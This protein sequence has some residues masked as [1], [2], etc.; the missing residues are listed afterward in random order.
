VMGELYLSGEGLA[1]GYYRRE[2]LSAEKFLD[3][4]FYD[5]QSQHGRRMYK[6]GDLVRW[7]DNGEL[8]YLGRIDN[9][10]KIRGFRIE[11]GE[12][13][14]QLGLC[15]DVESAFVLAKEIAG[16]KQ[17]VAYV[18][19]SVT[20]AQVE[21][22]KLINSIKQTLTLYLPDYMVP[23]IYVLL[24]S[25]PL[26][27]NGKIDQ[28]ALPE[29]QSGHYADLYTLPETHTEKAM[30]SIWS[31]LLGIDED[32]ICATTSFFEL[33]GNSLLVMRM[34]AKIK[35]AFNLKLNFEQLFREP[36][37]QSIANKLDCLV[38]VKGEEADQRTSVQAI[39]TT[40]RVLENGSPV[41]AFP[42]SFSQERLWFVDQFAPDSAVYN[43]PNAVVIDGELNA[44]DLQRAFNLIIAR[45]EILRS[46]FP[47]NNGVAQQIVLDALEFALH[48]TD[49]SQV[50]SDELRH[51]QAKELCQIEAEKPFDLAKGPLFRG[52]L[53]KLSD[54]QHIL[55]LV[56]H[57]IIT[58]GWSIELMI[59]EL[60]TIMD[61]LQQGKEPSLE[62][63]PIQYVD[64]S[65]WQRKRLQEDGLLEQQLD[66]W[67]NKLAGVPECLDLATDYP[68]PNVQ[69]SA[70]TR[71]SF[72]LGSELSSQLKSLADQQGCTLYMTLLA[73][74]N[75]LL[76]RYTGQED[77]C[78]GSPIANRQYAETQSLIGMFVNH[79]ALRN[80][81]DAE[82]S[83]YALLDQVKTTCL[84]A[85]ENQ[86]SPFEQVVDLVQPERNTSV[87]AL[88]QI[89]FILQNAS[90]Q[91]L[92]HNIRTYPLDYNFS[93]FDQV[94]T[95]EESPTGLKG[96]IEYKT[97]LYKPETIERM[98]E[99]FVSL[100][101]AIINAP[102]A[103]L[104][105]LEYVSNAEKQLLIHDN[106][107]TV[108]D[109]PQTLCIHQIFAQQAATHPEHLA[110]VEAQ[111]VGGIAENKQLTS[112][113]LHQYALELALYLQLQ[114]VKPDNLV[115]LCVGRSLGMMIGML[116]IF[117]AGGAYVPLDPDYPED[118]LSYMLQ[119]SQTKL[120]ITQASFVDK[121][122]ALV[123]HDTRIIVLDDKG[124]LPAEQRAQVER[125]QP[126]LKEEVRPNNLAYV[127]YTSGSTG[128]PKGVMIEHRMVIDYCYGVVQKM[129]LARCNTFASVSTFSSD[130][131]NIALFV[132]IL[133][134]KTLHLF[135]N[136]FI[137]NP[138][139]L[140]KYIAAHPIDCMKITPSHFEMF[141]VSD[142][143]IINVSKVLIFAGEPLT[144][145]MVELVNDLNPAVEVYNNYG[146]TETTISKLSSDAL[147]GRQLCTIPLGKPLNNTQ[148][149]VLD[150]NQMIQPVGV[151]GELY[152]A[153]HGVARGYLNQPELSQEKF[154]ANPFVDGER[155]YRTGDKVRWLEDGNIEFLG[156][157]D[158]QVKVRGF[159]IE[160][161]EIETCLNRYPDVKDSAV[162]VQGDG[163]NK[164]LIAFYTLQESAENEPSHDGFKAHILQTL[165]EYMLP[166]TYVCLETIPLTLNG[167]VNRLA[168]E[169]MDVT[170]ESTQMYVA[171][172]NEME[173]QL[174]D[175]WA[176]ILEIS[177][178]KIG[179]N[180]SF[181]ELGGHSLLAV[182][183]VSK[184]A[185]NLDLDLPLH[186]LFDS[187]TVSDIA[188]ELMAAQ[189]MLQDSEE[190]LEECEFEE[191]TL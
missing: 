74:F 8:E 50:D 179:V 23:D 120:V 69:V 169:R 171:P 35:S 89:V 9:Q 79:I 67:Q 170:L 129:A 44:A 28:M 20:S 55:V 148:L 97:A 146:P 98:A 150:E 174:V 52:M 133:F 167:K 135:C 72:E 118:R 10:V 84:E 1:R 54:E 37:I 190:N 32:K 107:Q 143:E 147:V 40:S 166:A 63:L 68:R 149:Y 140:H 182:L 160:P 139:E 25:W 70:G 7:L 38:A 94:V 142:T 88:F 96:V 155:M 106:N 128:K 154:V 4:P 49:L 159:R 66:Y 39:N 112:Q 17:L 176:E 87:S 29:P 131:G 36:T 3:N 101:R 53:L 92:A 15:D 161:G 116:G 11:I 45:H 127:I 43:V 165:P 141:K 123:S 144:K 51:Q 33:G 108:V 130:L 95:F 103:P 75:T 145:P 59:K 21:Q 77:I 64:Y 48:T 93:K 189:G 124:R 58:D 175:I 183:L 34:M 99:H 6:T 86:D 65:V 102:N 177:A 121:L 27:P 42:L 91:T 26:T 162:V 158:R 30:A 156:R 82:A 12:I 73:A 180:D 178:D 185:Q 136:D 62:P 138:I 2:A 78:L 137:K 173:Q 57:H 104:S 13:E 16:T 60:G 181:F 56:M 119:D 151:P 163:A 164:Q 117:Q 14:A 157:V 186:V 19:R 191:G 5:A 152:I 41:T 105:K 81:V 100:C 132:P 125:E 24:E 126:V 46:I 71:Y 122:Q 61:S 134:S 168:L 114:G 90:T 172:R 80:Q 111:L 47:D 184:V 83:F 76:Y 85:Y 31:E 18:Q 110:L 188:Q 115:G 22:A 153:G 113:Q 109:Y 187:P